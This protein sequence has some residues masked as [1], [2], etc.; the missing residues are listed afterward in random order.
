M[1]LYLCIFVC[2]C[3]CICVGVARAILEIA[4]EL[5]FIA[6]NIVRRAL[7]IPAYLSDTQT[8]GG[9][10]DALGGGW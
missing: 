6:G 3:L 4:I 5:V 2:L 10:A 7:V 8:A 9:S 1:Y